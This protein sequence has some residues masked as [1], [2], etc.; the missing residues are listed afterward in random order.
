M[1]EVHGVQPPPH[2]DRQGLVRRPDR[3]DA[4]E[5]L[6]AVHVGVHVDDHELRVSERRQHAPLHV[7]LQRRLRLPAKRPSCDSETSHRLRYDFL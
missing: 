4:G 7:P 3:A 2:L 6:A 1:H 5:V